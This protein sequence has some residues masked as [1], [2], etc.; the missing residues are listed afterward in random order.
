MREFRD[1]V[2]V[3][4]GAASGMGRAFAERFAREGMHVVLADVEAA[5]LNDAV[6]ALR[7]HGHD[8]IGVRT[9]VSRL[10]DVQHLARAAV[11][12]FGAIH[13]V[14]N[15]AGVDG[16]IDGPIW[17]PTDRD[18]LWTFGVNFWG[19]VHGV[20]TFLPLMLAQDTDGYM[21]NTASATGLVHANN[22]YGITKHAV[23]AL[24]EVV[25]SQL[26]QRDARVGISVLCPGV[27]N[28]RLFQAARN[29]PDELRNERPTSG[30]AAGE[31]FRAHMIERMVSAM[32]PAQVADSLLE[33]IR[34]EQFYVLTDTEW[35]ARIE[36]RHATIMQRASPAVGTRAM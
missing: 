14:C 27:V 36:S 15:K 20:R 33:A 19:V 34:R 31:Q 28:T 30:A 9:D 11:A 6:V 23:V 18:W 13:L 25:Y 29:R 17:E 2:A 8:A 21:V 1:R 12:A 26:K 22:M 16:D 7:E 4:T 32:P 24:S 35:D 5:A 10:V 3:V